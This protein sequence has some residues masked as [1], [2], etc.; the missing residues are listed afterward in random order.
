MVV[1]VFIGIC[2]SVKMK[3]MIKFLFLCLEPAWA[4]SECV[5]SQESFFSVAF[6]SP[7]HSFKGTLSLVD[8]HV[9]S[10]QNLKKSAWCFQVEQSH[11]QYGVDKWTLNTAGKGATRNVK[12]SMMA[13]GEYKKAWLKS[14]KGIYLEERIFKSVRANAS[15]HVNL[16]RCPFNC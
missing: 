12:E 8:M 10:I 6:L 15:A 11:F 14:H 3:T 16:W 13:E 7:L 1:W 9:R 4:W 5:C 2:I